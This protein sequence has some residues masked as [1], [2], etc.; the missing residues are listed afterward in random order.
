M[1]LRLRQLRYFVVVA[2]E[3]QITRAAAKLHL[4]QPALSQAITQLEGQLAVK[5]LERHPRGVSLTSA[6]EAFF[7]KARAALDAVAEADL[8][9]QSL[10]R[11]RR[12][13]VE[14]GFIGAPPMLD[15]PELF[16]AFAAVHPDVEVT[17]RELRFPSNSLAAWA[18]GVDLA[19]CFSPPPDANVHVHSLRAEPRAVV[20]AKTHPLT[21]RSERSVAEVLDETFVGFHPSVD[22][23]W[24]GFWHLDDHRGERPR[25]VTSDRA[26]NPQEMS[27]IIASGRA[28]IAAPESNAANLVKTL[29]DV[30]VIPLRDARPGDLS[31]VWH[32]NDPNMVVATLVATAR[33]LSESS[34]AG[35]QSVGA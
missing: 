16:A 1:S 34:P 2:E 19:L 35:G 20:A 3:G 22:P 25:R 27:A 24:A 10:S 21:Q 7:T 33:V 17:F 12:G 13:T 28:I 31:L 11:A 8:A 18:E 29:T 30:A 26:I 5:L 14:F 32:R 23:S 15:A 4:A 9:A 6:G